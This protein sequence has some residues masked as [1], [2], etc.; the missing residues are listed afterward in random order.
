MTQRDIRMAINEL[1]SQIDN[2][3][4]NSVFTLNKDIETLNNQIYGLRE[5][6]KHEFKDGV[7]IWCDLPEEMAND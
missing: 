2:N 3:L 4:R 6:C 7:C 1:Y 5:E